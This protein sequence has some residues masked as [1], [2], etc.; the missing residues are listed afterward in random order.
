MTRMLDES[1]VLNFLKRIRLRSVGATIL[2]GFAGLSLTTSIIPTAMSY[3]GIT[4]SFS[5][6]FALAGYA[7]YSVMAWSVGG[8]AAQ[9]IG[10]RGFGALILGLVGAVSGLV[11]TGL[12]LGTHAIVLLIGGGAALLYGAIGGMLIAD[13]LREPDRSGRSDKTDRD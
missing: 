6:R 8:W 3:L 11:F 12:G 10:D 7:V 4:D 1:A 5:A 2:G 13:A 9:K